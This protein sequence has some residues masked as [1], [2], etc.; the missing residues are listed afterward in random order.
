MDRSHLECGIRQFRLRQERSVLSRLHGMQCCTHPDILRERGTAE[1]DALERELS[2]GWNIWLAYGEHGSTE[3]FTRTQVLTLG[4][5]VHAG[6]I[7][8]EE[9]GK[10]ESDRRSHECFRLTCH[11]EIKQFPDRSESMM[12]QFTFYLPTFYR[13]KVSTSPQTHPQSPTSC[14]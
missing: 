2:I 8:R 14:P 12:N 7:T 6:R 10:H 3:V 1:N 11:F 4:H 9:D 5:G 13:C